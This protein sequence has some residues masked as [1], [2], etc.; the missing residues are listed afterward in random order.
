MSIRFARQLARSL[1]LSLEVGDLGLESTH[2]ALASA[3]SVPFDLTPHL[4]LVTLDEGDL[5]SA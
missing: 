2:T 5:V 1:Q 3:A 4:R